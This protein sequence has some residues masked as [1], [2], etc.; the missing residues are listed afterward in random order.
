MRDKLFTP[1]NSSNEETLINCDYIS[2]QKMN[3]TN[4]TIVITCFYEN[5]NPKELATTSFEGNNF[6][7]LSNLPSRYISNNG[8]KIIKSSISSDN[9]KS[10]VCYIDEEN[11][12]YCLIY[13]II[14]NEWRNHI[15]YFD[16]CIPKFSLFDT[17]Y[18]KTT[19]ESFIYCFPSNKLIY[20]I[21]IIITQ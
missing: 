4:E 7:L 8:A 5:E 3:I 11:S 1:T 10:F 2:L 9:T 19:N 15:K 13:D 18:F 17:L 20:F 16:T 21:L 6:N 12:C 14:K